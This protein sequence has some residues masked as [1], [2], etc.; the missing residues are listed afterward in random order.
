[1]YQLKSI[2]YTGVTNWDLSGEREKEATA[3]QAFT[4]PGAT[5]TESK[6]AQHD[7]SGAQRL[8]SGGGLIKNIG[9]FEIR[10]SIVFKI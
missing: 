10:E 1:V 8:D 2:S 3:K 7:A 9:L 6:A 4:F 5:P